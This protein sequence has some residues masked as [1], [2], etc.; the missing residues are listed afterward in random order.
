MVGNP[1]RK[2][3]T[4]T[5]AKLIIW[6]PA[7]YERAMVRRAAIFIL[8]KLGAPDEDVARATW[9]LSCGSVT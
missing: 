1:E 3:M 9:F 5:Q 6:H 4:Y 2:P 8:A 7:T